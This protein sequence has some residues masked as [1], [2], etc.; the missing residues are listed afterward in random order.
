MA[1]E[2]IKSLPRETAARV[3]SL[4]A[5]SGGER[6]AAEWATHKQRMR[7]I[8]ANLAIEDMPL[9][10]DELAFF[11]FAFGL[12]VAAEE[13]RALLRLWNEERRRPPVIAA[14]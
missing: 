2:F 5:R 13:E 3:R 11:D 8:Q 12:N 10:E 7:E 4:A 1:D 9:R 14:E 6:T